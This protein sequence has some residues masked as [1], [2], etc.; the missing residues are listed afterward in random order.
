MKKITTRREAATAILGVQ[1][2]T[3]RPAER[4]NHGSQTRIEGR[5]GRRD[6]R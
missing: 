2:Q 5:Y 4:G 1:A 3:H 6:S